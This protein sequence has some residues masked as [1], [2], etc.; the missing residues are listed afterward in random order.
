MVEVRPTNLCKGDSTMTTATMAIAE[1]AEKS[2]ERL[3]SR[4]RTT[5]GA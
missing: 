5:S 3:N 2:A 1:L 4:S